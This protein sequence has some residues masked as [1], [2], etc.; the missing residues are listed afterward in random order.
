MD[1]LLTKA[2]SVVSA[3]DSLVSVSK[4][5]RTLGKLLSNVY[6]PHQAGE[7]Q[8]HAAASVLLHRQAED[9]SVT[10]HH[11]LF[12]NNVKYVLWKKMEFTAIDFTTLK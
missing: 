11:F 2:G 6:H 5:K 12:L 1:K 9:R 8:K 4:K 7:H 10:A 3:K